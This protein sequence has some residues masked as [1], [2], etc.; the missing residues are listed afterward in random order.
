M[1][2]KPSLLSP[3]RADAWIWSILKSVISDRV[4]GLMLTNP[5]TL[6]L[7]ENDIA[8]ISDL[9]H[10]AG[11]LMYCDGANMNALVGRARPG[12]MGFD[13]M[14]YNLHKTFSS[15]HGGGGPGSGPCRRQKNTWNRF[16]PSRWF[17][18]VRMEHT[19]RD[20]DR[21]HTVGKI[22][23]FYG[24]FMAYLR[25]YLFILYYG[26]EGLKEICGKCRL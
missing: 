5:N 23:S 11:G 22:H 1:D 15:P 16:C 21:P 17:P 10:K 9:V 26:R 2:T 4:A 7:F 3:T 13:V 18:F 14:H 6:G 12:D 8:E 24:S 25:A 19:Y 20:F